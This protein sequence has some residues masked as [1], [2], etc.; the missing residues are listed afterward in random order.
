MY[1]LLISLNTVNIIFGCCPLNRT[2]KIDMIYFKSCFLSFQM[3]VGQRNYADF[4]SK[5][6]DFVKIFCFCFLS[7]GRC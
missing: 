1:L 3:V 2:V 5:I 7:D 6:I 4:F